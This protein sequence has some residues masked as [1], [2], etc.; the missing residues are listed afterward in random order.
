MNEFEF[1]MYFQ[2][3]YSKHNDSNENYTDNIVLTQIV[4]HSDAPNN[5]PSDYYP[6]YHAQYFPPSTRGLDEGQFFLCSIDFPTSFPVRFYIHL[7]FI[8]KLI[9][10]LLGHFLEAGVKGVDVLG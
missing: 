8:C 5:S 6:Q 4:I 9:K 3:E 10:G 7:C 2:Q 1:G